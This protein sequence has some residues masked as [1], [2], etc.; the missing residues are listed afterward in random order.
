VG[1]RIALRTIALG[2][3]GL[4]L[5]APVVYLLYRTFEHGLTAP[6]EAVTSDVALHA[7][8]LTVVTAAIAVPINTVLGIAA[9]IVLVRHRFPGRRV[10]DAIIDLP[11]AL[12]PV[13]IGLAILLLFGRQGWFGP[14][15]AD[16]GIQVIFALPGMVIA[17]IIVSLPFVVREVAPVLEELGDEQEQAARTLGASPWQI[18]RR[19]TL[20]SVKGAVT[21]GVILATARALGEFGA[22]AIVSGKVIGQTETLTIHVE[23]RFQQFDLTGAYASSTVLALLAVAVLL[24]MRR[25]NQESH[26]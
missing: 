17:T 19:I 12:S 25:V 22:V 23:E 26:R 24:G 21:Y 18:F 14:S 8:Y 1:S 10:L 13:V 5:L 20:P 11:F 7:L 15:F 16:A 9:A 2:Y 6:I 4:L 3:L